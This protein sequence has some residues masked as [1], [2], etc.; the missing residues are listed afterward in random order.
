MNFNAVIENYRNV[1]IQ[2][3]FCFEGRCGRKSFWS[4]VLVNFVISSVL[5]LLPG[6]GKILGAI[7]FLAVLA[8]FLGIT[9]RR[10][11]DTGRSGW[12]QLLALIPVIGALIVLILCIPEGSREANKYGEPAEE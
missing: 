11:H 12:L 5:G 9:T 1:V 10:L 3:Y 7:F 4:F 2:K 6:V 8:P